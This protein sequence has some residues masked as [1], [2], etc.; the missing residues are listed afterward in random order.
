[1]FVYLS[2]GAISC[3]KLHELL[4][5]SMSLVMMCK[6]MCQTEQVLFTKSFRH[7]RKVKYGHTKRSGAAGLIRTKSVHVHVQRTKVININ[8]ETVVYNNI[9]IKTDF[10][11][12]CL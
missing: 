4:P 6:L 1:M 8:K 11:I 2:A 9:I 12:C 10:S 7:L 3:N 5:R